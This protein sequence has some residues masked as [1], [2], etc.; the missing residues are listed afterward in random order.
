MKKI[1]IVDKKYNNLIKIK[2]NWNKI[3]LLSMEMIYLNSK[4]N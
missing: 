1:Q 3:D 4:Q 2:I